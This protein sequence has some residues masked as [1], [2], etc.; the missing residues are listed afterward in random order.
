MREAEPRTSR[1]HR[2]LKCGM[3]ASLENLKFFI[4]ENAICGTL[5]TASFNKKLINLTTN[6]KAFFMENYRKYFGNIIYEKF[7]SLEKI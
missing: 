2:M 7:Q 4:L 1:L 6:N 5:K 3:H